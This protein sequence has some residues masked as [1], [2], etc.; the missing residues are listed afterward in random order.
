MNLLKALARTS[1]MTM[2]SRVLGLVRETMNARFYGAGPAYDAFMVAFRLPNMFRRI[3]AEGAFS[4]AF[5][6]ILA[7]YKAQ[8]GEDA[9]REFLA[10]VAGWLTMAL[11]VFTIVGVLAA[12]ATV[13]LLASGFD[14]TGERFSLAVALTRITFPYILLISLASL[15]G[16]VLNTWNRFSIPAF[17]PALLNV[18]M[19]LCGYFLSPYF[20]QPIFA[21][22]ISVALGGVL[23]LGFQLPYLRQ[24]GML[25]RP[26]L[27]LGAE[28]VWRVLRLM[29]PAMF[30]VSVSQI[31][32]L[33]NTNFASRLPA[34]SISWMSYSDR[35]MELP[36]GVLGV[37]LGTILL[38]SLSKLRAAGDQQ[39]YAATLD[40]GLRLCW[41]LALPAS[42]ALGT[43]AEPIVATLLRNGNFG[44]HDVLM[45]ERAL[46]GYAV[47]LMGLIVI[48][49]LAPAYYARQD[50][51]TPVKIAIVSLITTQ[52]LNF[53]LIGPLAHAG[54]A[55]AISLGA[56]VNATLL[57]I[58]LYRS[59]V[60]QP[61][62][63]WAGFALRLLVAV[64]VMAGVLLLLA[65][66][67]GD[68]GKGAMLLRAAKLGLLVTAG[69]STY[70]GSL[71]ALG[72]RPRDFNRHAA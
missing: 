10:D 16:S 67:L 42:V 35:L 14:T 46:I 49:I 21:L 39:A 25:P 28:G 71:Y 65:P 24:I 1:S 5:V 43:I 32:L 27:R 30:G 17:T 51:K 31:S 2:I 6:P 47:G 8:R 68:W 63:G 56:C 69:A 15:A 23:Q 37:A 61:A 20:H 19:I 57:F 9:A 41:L 55:L 12:P 34:G 40:W 54:L 60:Y 7:E 13:Y 72:F 3:F 38:P 50:I 44:A 52:A 64:T 58:G 11:L 33:L 18:S 36:T 62:P 4:Q 29:G 66:L 70:F 45:T 59:G 53:V 22:A 26:R 48:K